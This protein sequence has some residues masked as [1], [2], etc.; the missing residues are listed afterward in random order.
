MTPPDKL[1]TMA[2]QIAR[3]FAHEGEAGAV[4]ST[5]D[6][7]VKFW[8][9]SMRADIRRYV[10]EGGEGLLPIARGAVET[11]PATAWPYGEERPTGG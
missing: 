7:L 9:P 11:L 6:H 5:R 8:H 3:A 1:V 2:N 4:V 10:A